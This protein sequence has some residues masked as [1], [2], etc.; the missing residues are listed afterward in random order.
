MTYNNYV[1]IPRDG[2]V[3]EYLLDWDAKDTAG[4]NN[5]T[6][7]N[8]TWVNSEKGYTSDTG[9]FNGSSSKVQCSSIPTL[10]K[11]NPFTVS[12]IFKANDTS[13]RRTLWTHNLGSSDRIWVAIEGNL[14]RTWIFNWSSYFVTTNKS[15]TD[16]SNYYL[17]TVTFDWVSTLKTYLNGAEYT[18]WTS[19]PSLNASVQELILWTKSDWDWDFSWKLSLTRIY[20]RVLSQDEVQVLYQEWL[21]KF[22]PT[23]SQAAWMLTNVRDWLVSEYP[24]NGDT[25]DYEWTN[26]WTPSNLSY[27]WVWGWL[28][29]SFNGS[30]SYITATNSYTWNFTISCWVKFD[31]FKSWETQIYRITWAWSTNIGFSHTWTGG[32]N[33]FQLYTNNGTTWDSAI[34]TWFTPV[35]NTWYYIVAR[36]DWTNKTITVVWSWVEASSTTAPSVTLSWTAYF[37]KHPTAWGRELDWN[38]LDFN[39]YNKA[40]SQDEIDT[41]YTEWLKYINP[42]KYSLSKLEDNKV[43]EISQAQSGWS[44]IDQTGNWNNGTPTNVTDSTL[45]LNNVMD[46]NGSSSRIYWTNTSWDYLTYSYLVKPTFSGG[47]W[48]HIH[49]R[50]WAWADWYWSV[51]TATT[52]N[53]Y[54]WI[55]F[56]VKNWWTSL[57]LQAENILVAWEWQMITVVYDGTKWYIYR[58]GVEITSTNFTHW[59]L[60]NPGW[61]FGIG[62]SNPVSWPQN[63][64]NWSISEP[65]IYSRALSPEEVQQDF[66]SNYIQS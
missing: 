14:I 37:G 23:Q 48:M 52:N 28:A 20:N 53:N 59:T 44:Y 41:L 26:N 7:T 43:L 10:S 60:P 50:N 61:S 27:E 9:S 65:K 38:L 39:I 46:F 36:W 49:T 19:T 18:W 54:A 58:N 11:S 64:F 63:Y 2:L 35:V 66:Y 31:A 33:T 42:H 15:F 3:A 40:L 5:W 62:E 16:T 57:N 8:V 1:N 13:S 55:R 56:Y 34:M 51:D 21:R 29:S 45:W 25:L 47:N 24:L 32:S 6:A 12:I 17:H 22:W 4:S 30:S